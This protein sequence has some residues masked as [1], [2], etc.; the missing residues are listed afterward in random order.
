MPQ[1]FGQRFNRDRV[2]L[3]SGGVFDFDAVG[4]DGTTIG[5]IS[6]SS[7]KTAAESSRSGS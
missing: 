2:R 4:A 3:T 5:T 7:A 6:T 1:R